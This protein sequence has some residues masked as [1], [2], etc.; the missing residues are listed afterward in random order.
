MT[1][2]REREES[3]LDEAAVDRMWTGIS[4]RRRNRARLRHAGQFLGGALVAGVVVFVMRDA[5]SVRREGA[6][7]AVAV[8]T[9][10]PMPPLGPVHLANGEP[11]TELL[12]V[13]DARRFDLDDGSTVELTAGSR[14]RVTANS[15]AVVTLRLTGEGVFEVRPGGPRR[16]SV[17]ANFVTVDVIGTRFTVRDLTDGPQPREQVAVDHGVVVVRGEKVPG[18]VVRLVDG[19]SIVVPGLER[20]SVAAPDG[21]ARAAAPTSGGSGRTWRDLAE[22]GD[23]DAAYRQLG[24][25]GVSRESEA[26]TVDD[27]FALADV[28][29]LSAHA[30][31]A[32]AP[33]SRVVDEHGSDPR[34]AVAA[35]TLGKLQEDTLHHPAAAATALSRALSLGLPEGLVEDAYARL[36]EADVRAGA[37][38]AARKARA[39][40]ARRYPGGSRSSTMD[41]WIDGAAEAPT[42]GP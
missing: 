4:A 25:E 34:A 7:G 35:F 19:Q 3:V 1:D 23:Y 2:A 24:A 37:V 40:Y 10:S 29:R 17:E 8:H 38:D 28:A 11:L 21:R 26:A 22:R 31:D 15:G 12:A 13:N 36:V 9:A 6:D 27:L 39:E 16:W 33:L 14:A 30:V 42:H 5:P 20:A 18:H 32:V 41:R